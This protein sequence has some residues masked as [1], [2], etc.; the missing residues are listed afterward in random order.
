[1]RRSLNLTRFQFLH[2]LLLTNLAIL[3]YA[4]PSLAL[5]GQTLPQVKQWAKRSFILPATL[6]YNPEVDAYTGIRTV[7]GGLLA[8][9]VKVRPQDQV[10]TQEQ[11]VT[12]RNLPNLELTRENAA[13]LKFIQRVYN[14]EIA[15]DFHRAKY[16]AQVGN[17][18]FYQGQQFVYIT[19]PRVGG[20]QRLKVVP[21]SDLTA[22]I[23][24]E[25]SCLTHQCVVYQPFSPNRPEG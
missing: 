10:V 15:E 2:N 20:I 16:V 4:S 8:L 1:M 22:A 23:E 13:G 18:S 24:Q 7:E 6:T 19:Y 12:Q 5:P 14:A 25:K 9:M 11:I 3:L 17:T 21:T